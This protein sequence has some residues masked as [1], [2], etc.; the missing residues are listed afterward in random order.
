MHI[1]HS[2]LLPAFVLACVTAD[3]RNPEPP[4]TVK[5]VIE[6]YK[7][8]SGITYDI[9]YRMKFFDSEEIFETQSSVTL[10][11]L[12]ADTIFGSKFSYH[13]KD[14]LTDLHKY[15]DTRRLW[16]I[17][18]KERKAMEFD[19]YK[20]QTHPVT[21]N[22]DGNVLKVYFTDIERLEK[23][24]ANNKITAT[25]TDS[26]SYLKVQL[27]LPDD[28]EF[29]DRMEHIYIHQPT[30]TISRI[31]YHTRYQDQV[32]QN[33]WQLSNIRF[34]SIPDKV[35]TSQTKHFLKTYNK[36]IY[37]PLTEAD[38]KLLD[39]GITA[40]ALSGNWYPDYLQRHTVQ[41]GKVTILDFWYTSCM[42]CI[43]AIPNLNQLQQKY[44]NAIQIIGVNQVEHKEADAP[45]IAAFLQRTPVAY[46]ILLIDSIPK[47]Y[48]VKAYPTLYILDKDGKVAYA[49]IGSSETLFEDLDAI[50]GPLVK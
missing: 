43:K 27:R 30:L 19:P 16:V 18:H 25:Y 41:S 15:Y 4:Q 12:P 29:Y 8:Q 11:K 42:P 32:Q 22:V 23:K 21:G 10:Q 46:P 13:R 7:K 9:R 17:D 40:P 14:S 28:D 34:G 48:N 49:A 31:T 24:L 50:I 39:S 37:K 1:L 36:E 5:K 47:A 20:D 44:G 26:S 6:K 35:F 45:R 2:I 33:D 38:Y 3:A